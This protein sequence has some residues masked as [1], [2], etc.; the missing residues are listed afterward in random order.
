MAAYPN[1]N[2]AN[3]YARDIIDGKIVACRAIR[4]ACQ[5]H[6]DDLKKSLDNN[7]PYRFDRDLAERACRFVQKLPH[8]SGDLAGQK[9]KLEPWQSFIFCSIFGWVTKKDKKTP[10]SR[11]VYPGSQE[12]REIVFCCRDWHL[13]VLR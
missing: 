12:K 6:F 3:K 2:V 7:Y 11:S 9:L 10:I 8:S 5:R 4:L 1:V 13:H